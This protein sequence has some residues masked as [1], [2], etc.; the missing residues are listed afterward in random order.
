MSE[1]K[2]IIVTWPACRSLESYLVKLR[3]AAAEEKVI[4]FK[5]GAMPRHTAAGQRC[6]MVHSGYVR[7]FCEIIDLQ[8]ENEGEPP[9]DP[10]SG[11]QMSRGNYIVRSPHW[12]ELGRQPDMKGFQG[13]R[14]AP[15]WWR[16]IVAAG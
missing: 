13:F 8:F 6:Y 4:L 3:R 9:I 2:D 7:G 1:F 12:W 14:Y 11:K 15:K 5:V 16:E 10:I